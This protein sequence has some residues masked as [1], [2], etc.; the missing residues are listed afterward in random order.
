MIIDSQVHFWT[1]DT[2]EHPWP[3]DRPESRTQ[4]G[5]P[6]E[7]AEMFE[8]M[9]VAGVDRVVIVPPIWAADDNADAVRWCAEYPDKFGIM[10]RF[11][12]WD[13]DRDRMQRWLEQPGMLGIRTSYPRYRGRD[14]IE[15]P[16]AFAWFWESAQEL[17]IPIMLLVQDATLIGNLAERFPELVL[18][19]DHL[20]LR[21]R[22]GGRD[23]R[24]PTGAFE[25]F[26]ETLKIARFPHVNVK[27]SSLPVY[28]N[29]D[30]PYPSMTPFLKQA[31]DAFGPQRIMWGSDLTR[32]NQSTYKD[33][34]DAPRIPQ[35]YV[36]CLEHVRNLEFLNEDD[37]EWIL[38]RTASTLLNWP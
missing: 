1:A 2:P 38:G 24:T 28:T 36:D 9:E 33:G 25:G 3:T 20:G 34:E 31:Y 35:Q 23:T 6:M 7:P 18:I 30:F 14:W 17:H 5:Q 22:P 16:E 8:L 32:L 26:E 13:A 12:L 21:F 4:P 27:F 10:G 11:D 15:D 37:K 29:E 19:L